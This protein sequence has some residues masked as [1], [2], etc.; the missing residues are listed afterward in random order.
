M[1]KL[2]SQINGRVKNRKECF[3]VT[4]CIYKLSLTNKML[5][6]PKFISLKNFHIQ[7]HFFVFMVHHPMQYL[8]SYFALSSDFY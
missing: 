3:R 2:Q 4:L 5:F 8:N 6:F 7:P 1:K